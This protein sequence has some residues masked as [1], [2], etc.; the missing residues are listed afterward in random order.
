MKKFTN[1][2]SSHMTG[3]K[4]L[5]ADDSAY[6]RSVI[7][8]ALEKEDFEVVGESGDGETTINLALALNP[9]LII[10]ENILP[11]MIG[12]DII[13]VLQVKNI[14]SKVIVM[15]AIG[16]QSVKRKGRASDETVYLNKP[17]TSE[18]LVK[19]IFSMLTTNKAA[20][21]SLQA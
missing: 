12:V 1:I 17:F 13:R 9:D 11:D 3:K 14:C 10:L 5:I 20:T 8:L 15:S 2:D 6:M 4:I 16:H 19:T 21:Y 7:K 18:C